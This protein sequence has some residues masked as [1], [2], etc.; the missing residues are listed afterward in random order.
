MS[1][2]VISMQITALLHKRWASIVSDL[3]IR[4]QDAFFPEQRQHIYSNSIGSWFINPLPIHDL[5]DKE[6][7][8]IKKQTVTVRQL[9][10]SR[11]LLT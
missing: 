1:T 4:N 3:N 9:P 6:S 11:I 2:S 7:S 10:D 8:F 5:T